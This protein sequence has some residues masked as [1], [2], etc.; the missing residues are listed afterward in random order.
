MSINISIC[1]LAGTTAGFN[2]TTE[3]FQLG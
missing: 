3:S 2:H 1:C